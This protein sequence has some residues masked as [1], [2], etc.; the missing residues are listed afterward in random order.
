MILRLL[1]HFVQLLP[2]QSALEKEMLC[3]PGIFAWTKSSRNAANPSASE[4]AGTSNL[5]AGSAGVAG[6][7]VGGGNPAGRA[8]GLPTPVSLPVIRR[9][10]FENHNKD[11]GLWLIIDGKVYDIQDFKCAYT[12]FDPSLIEVHLSYDQSDH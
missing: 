7:V 8:S 12:I 6:A 1:D 5:G 3:W 4:S 9:A 10:E 11:G 2:N